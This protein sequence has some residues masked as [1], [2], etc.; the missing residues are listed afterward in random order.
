VLGQ[1]PTN[2]GLARHGRKMIKMNISG[3]HL[4][5][6]LHQFGRDERTEE[7]RAKKNRG[8]LRKTERL[9]THGGKKKK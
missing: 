5:L 8:F 3:L 6:V 4:E 1:K 2:V 9:N 7:I